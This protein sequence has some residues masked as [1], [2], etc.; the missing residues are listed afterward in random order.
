MESTIPDFYADMPCLA[1]KSPVFVQGEK[2]D[3]PHRTCC[4]SIHK[5]VV[6]DG[7]IDA[8]RESDWN[9]PQNEE[10]HPLLRIPAIHVFIA[11]PFFKLY[12][13]RN[14]VEIAPKV[15]GRHRV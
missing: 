12:R 1:A 5:I 3:D 14:S 2:P 4:K 15:S 11:M 13:H 8:H 9:E 6:L 10:H 7:F